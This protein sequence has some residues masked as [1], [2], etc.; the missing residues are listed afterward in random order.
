MQSGVVILPD[1]RWS[2]NMECWVAAEE[3]GFHSA[4][5]YDHLWWRSLRD[6]PWF[7][8]IPILS[9]VA[10]LTKNIRLGTM[11]SSP[12]I[13]NPVVLAKE[14]M[15]IDDLSG[16]RFTLGLG[17]G[18]VGAGDTLSVS[19]DELSTAQRLERFAE[20][21]ESIDLLLREPVA[22]FSGEFYEFEEA[23]MI[24]GCIQEPRVPLLIAATGKRAMKATAG[25]A[26]SWVSTGATGLT[27]PSTLDEHMSAL[28]GQLDLLASVCAAIGRDFAEF[29]KV[30]L[31]PPMADFDPI[32]SLGEYLELHERCAALGVHQ[33]VVHWPRADGVYAGS[34]D[35]F[36][37]IAQKALP[38]LR[39]L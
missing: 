30:F 3:L 34:L 19:A 38:Q 35:E 9:A 36:V 8:A 39:E 20:F 14:T 2:H 29:E 26:D 4:W 15:T 1:R 27:V 5:T 25:Y 17:A 31:A 7:S 33:V 6:G 10:C 37:E 18:S 12:N 16:G 24:P 32:G 22:S 28:R 13:R 21:V 11:V 23:R